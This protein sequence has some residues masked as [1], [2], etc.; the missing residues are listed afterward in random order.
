MKPY[1]DTN[2]DSGVEAY[3]YGNDW[4]DVRFGAGSTRNYRYESAK[5]GQSHIETMKRLA[6]AGDGL[7]AYINTHRDVAKGYSKRW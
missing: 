4:I 3:D 5:I 2:G 1:R 6:D 7:N